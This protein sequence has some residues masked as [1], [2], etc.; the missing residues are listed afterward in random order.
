MVNEALKIIFEK[1]KQVK[2]ILVINQ[3]HL[4][5][6]KQILLTLR[7]FIKLFDYQK[8]EP[9]IKE[10]LHKSVALI[11]TKA[12]PPDEDEDCVEILKGLMDAWS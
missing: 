6:N 2:F 9:T 4:E 7:Y 5:E 8:L 10:N 11:I 1:I 12:G 3:T